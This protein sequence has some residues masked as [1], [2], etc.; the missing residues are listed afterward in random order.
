MDEYTAKKQV[1]EAGHELVA[2][3]L[4]VRTWGNISCRIDE[5][6]FAVTPSGMGY[7]RLTP[8]DIVTV[9]CETL[10][11]FGPHKPSGET[12]IHAAVYRFRPQAGF[13]VHTHQDCAS[14]ISVAGYE[15]LA[16][17]AKEREI[18]GGDGSV[19]RAAYGLPCSQPL[20]KRVTRVL[21][22]SD[23][24]VLFMV[25]HGL[26]SIGSDDQ[27]AFLR[28][29]VVEDMCARI[30]APIPPQTGIAFDPTNMIAAIQSARPELKHIRLVTDPAILWRAKKKRRLIPMLDDFA[31]LIGED[32]GWV[33]PTDLAGAATAI[34]DRN[35]LLVAGAG[36]LVAAS[37]PSDVEAI[38]Y[39]LNKECV[40]ECNAAAHGGAKALPPED[41]KIMRGIYINAYSK[42]K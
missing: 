35:A 41:R 4:I 15:A 32:I 33:E 12:G 1:V 40:T 7:D 28:A 26:L 5:R 20:C 16:P 42:L 2:R 29:Q 18:L 38:H 14:A 24:N 30:V 13:A 19:P 39:L 22:T 36:A 37:D 25:R 6:L 27:Q 10:E 9:D 17:T 3:G 34:E 31:Q 21:K 23:A 8:E 11:A